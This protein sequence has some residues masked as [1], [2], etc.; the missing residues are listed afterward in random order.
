MNSIKMQF[1]QFFFIPELLCSLFVLCILCHLCSRFCDLLCLLVNS[2]RLLLN[3]PIR[4]K[5]I[6]S[7]V[8]CIAVHGRGRFLLSKKT[9]IL[10]FSLRF[11]DF[12][13]SHSHSFYK[14]SLAHPLG[15]GG[16]VQFNILPLSAN[17]T[18][19]SFINY[20]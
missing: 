5:E 14:T 4:F 8:R 9:Q 19:P 18:A 2:F 3:F 16:G 1:K 11:C 7:L 13:T 12:V 17:S 6:L 10:S 15:E 20:S